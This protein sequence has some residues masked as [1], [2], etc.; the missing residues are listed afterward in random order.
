MKFQ[1]YNRELVYATA[2]FMDVFNNIHIKRNNGKSIRVKCLNGQRS[3]IYK[4]L[5]NPDRNMIQP[6]LIAVKRVGISRD[7]ARVADKNRHILQQTG[8]IN[9]DIYPPNPLNITFELSII[10]KYQGD[11]DMILSNFLPFTN[12]S[13]FVKT[14]NP[15]NPERT[16]NHEVVWDGEINEDD[17]SEIDFTE[18]DFR[19]SQTTFTFKTWIW[20]GEPW[21]E[22]LNPGEDGPLIK[23]INVQPNL[24]SIGTQRFLWKNGVATAED[25]SAISG[26]LLDDEEYYGDIYSLS[27]WYALDRDQDFGEYEGLIASGHIEPPYYDSLPISGTVSGYVRDLGLDLDIGDQFTLSGNEVYFVDNEGGIVVYAGDSAL[28]EPFSAECMTEI[29]G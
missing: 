6:P 29:S 24:C 28:T 23:K 26:F 5:E 25:L 17:K 1:S 21:D 20:P 15:K 22:N 19:E 14:P 8:A 27:H 2:M 13:F 16:I 11:M 3:R 9:Y 12:Q 4:S 10:T 18:I 7:P